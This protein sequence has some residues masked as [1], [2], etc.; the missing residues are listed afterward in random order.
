[1]NKLKM[2]FCKTVELSKNNTSNTIS[3]ENDENA[4]KDRENSF[5][6]LVES[7]ELKKREEDSREIIEDYLNDMI[8][9]CCFF[10]FEDSPLYIFAEEVYDLD[11]LKYYVIL[12]SFSQSGK[13]KS[14]LFS[15]NNGVIRLARSKYEIRTSVPHHKAL[16]FEN[17]NITYTELMINFFSHYII[18]LNNVM[19]SKFIY[20]NF[21]TSEIPNMLVRLINLDLTRRAFQ[22]VNNVISSQCFTI[23]K[24]FTIG[25]SQNF[26]QKNEEYIYP[27]QK[28]I[29]INHLQTCKK[30]EH[31]LREYDNYLCKA[32]L[33]SIIANK[34]KW[35][36]FEEYRANPLVDLEDFIIDD[37]PSFLNTIDIAKRVGKSILDVDL[38]YVEKNDVIHFIKKEIELFKKNFLKYK[39]IYIH[40]QD[41]ESFYSMLEYKKVHALE[42]T[43]PDFTWNNTI[44]RGYVREYFENKL[45]KEQIYAF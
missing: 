15:K 17:Q 5:N 20:E 16:L 43:T 11:D 1:M 32:V 3:S 42:V 35:P 10:S 19:F 12:Y 31:S 30:N 2:F 34:G 18:K 40:I 37:K 38:V 29:F 8:K 4:I 28:H 27:F 25:R 21:S 26:I 33:D 39:F 7:I 45:V 36:E 13:M 44:V 24:S 23:D 9:D 6:I 22:H 41:E 14:Y